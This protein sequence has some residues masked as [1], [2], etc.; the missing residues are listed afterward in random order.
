MKIELFLG[1]FI[2]QL[3]SKY[4]IIKLSLI[5]FNYTSIIFKLLYLHI[6]PKNLSNECSIIKSRIPKHFVLFCIIR[7]FPKCIGLLL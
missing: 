5:I 7:L 1:K 2:F 4:Q 6:Y 3:S